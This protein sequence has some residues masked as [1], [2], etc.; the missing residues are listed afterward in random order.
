MD[1]F[2]IFHVGGRG[3]I[4]PASIFLTFCG[5]DGALV[6]VTDADP[7]AKEASWAKEI[8]FCISDKSAKG[9]KFYITA[10]PN[11]SSL[12]KTNPE[13]ASFADKDGKVWGRIS[14]TMRELE[15]ETISIDELVKAAHIQQPDILSID[16][17][18]AEYDIL[19]GARETLK[20]VLAVV[21]EVE[22]HPIYLNQKLFADQDVLLRNQGF[23]LCELFNPQHW[24]TDTLIWQTSGG[25]LTVAEALYL[26]DWKLPVNPEV[27]ARLAAI[28]AGFKIYSYAY[29]IMKFLEESFPEKLRE[30][31]GRS[32]EF[33]W[34]GVCDPQSIKRLYAV[35]SY[36]DVMK[37][38]SR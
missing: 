29:D 21:T 26:R 22:F 11:A 34:W 25:F 14:K 36:D 16:A 8:S 38:M 5:K 24:K 2:N 1:K 20:Q 13:A 31:K 19:Q 27:L 30:L 15:V 6:T 28:A 32:N 4:G 17:Q 3:D 33:W 37:E 7:G 35:P 9:V 18:G 10:D 23:R 12:L